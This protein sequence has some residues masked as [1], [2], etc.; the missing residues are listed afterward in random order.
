MFTP[1]ILKIYRDELMSENNIGLR[2]IQLLEPAEV[3]NKRFTSGLVPKSTKSIQDACW[4]D[5]WMALSGN[6]S[7]RCQCAACGKLI[8]ADTSDPECVKLAAAY[9]NQGIIPDCKPETLQIQGGHIVLTQDIVDGR[10]LLAKKGS[11][12]IVPLCKECN[13]SHVI[14]LTLQARTII[15]PEVR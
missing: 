1:R 14:T 11:T 12:H 15:T 7:G 3:Q 2:S 5:Q 8:F 9:R 10:F 6:S 13:N 4:T